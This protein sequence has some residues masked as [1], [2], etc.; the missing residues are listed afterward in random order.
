MYDIEKAFLS[1][2]LKRT[3]TFIVLFLVVIIGVAALTEFF[4]SA[5][6]TSEF[7]KKT[8]F[9]IV[10]DAEF[11][12]SEVGP[13]DEVAVSPVVTSDATENMYVVIVVDMP[14][15][16][17]SPIYEYTVD[18]S[19]TQISDEDSLVYGYGSSDEMTVLLPGDTTTPLTESLLMK[20]FTIPEYAYIDDINVT[21]NVYALGAD[22]TS[23]NPDEVWAEIKPPIFTL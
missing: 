3:I 1:M 18:G 17:G 5:S 9:Q 11:P 6:A 19:W 13:G 8:F 4:T 2:K 22:G 10:F 16:E 15:F 7:E 12:S 23:S 21:F 20:N 14:V